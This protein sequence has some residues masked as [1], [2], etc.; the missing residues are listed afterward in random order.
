MSRGRLSNREGWATTRCC[1]WHRSRREAGVD[2]TWMLMHSAMNRHKVPKAL[3]NGRGRRV[4]SFI[5]PHRS[6]LVVFLLLTVVSAV[7]TVTTP[8]L[9]GEVGDQ[10]GGH[11]A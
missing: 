9:A 5:G 3:A 6:M 10:I 7:L 1:A 2:G 11:G 8:L 4:L